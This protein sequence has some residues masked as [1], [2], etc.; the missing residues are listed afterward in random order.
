MV[1]IQLGFLSSMQK[2][3][4]TNTKARRKELSTQEVRKYD[5]IVVDRQTDEDESRSC[6]GLALLHI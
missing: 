4:F 6:V 2:M 5:W 3:A 1:V